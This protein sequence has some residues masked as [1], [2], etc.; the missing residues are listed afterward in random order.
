MQKQI[1]I[2][3]DNA[4]SGLKL[5]EM[6]DALGYGVRGPYRNLGDGCDHA[7]ADKI[8]FALLDFDLSNWTDALPIAEILTSR[9]IGFT[10]ATA[11]GTNAIRRHIAGATVVGKPVMESE[12]EA[13]LL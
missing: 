12:L 5:R 2:V 8:D 4:I 3:E 6:V 7:R 1:L 9:H 13:A 11:T 10:L